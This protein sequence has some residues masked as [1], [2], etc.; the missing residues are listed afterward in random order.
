M[1]QTNEIPKNM[2]S[3][4][5]VLGSS[6]IDLVANVS[7]LPC[8]GETV[9]GARLMQANGGKGANQ[10]VAAARLGG[11]VTFVT[12]LGDDANGEML[13]G[14][15][16]SDG[17][18]TSH[19][20]TVAGEPTGTALIFV[21]EEGENCIAVVPGANGFLTKEVVDSVDG[22]FREAGFMLLQLETPLDA[23]AYAIEKAHAQGVKVILNPAPAAFLPDEVF[24]CLHLIT[25][26]ETEAELL[27]GVKVDSPANA[28]KAA[29]ILL[30]KGVG[31]VVITL[32]SEGAFIKT[33]GT[34]ELVPALKVVAK[35]S[36]AAGDTFSG[37]LTVALSEGMELR[38]AVEFATAAAAISVTRMGAQPS[39][40]YRNEL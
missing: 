16:Q 11:D 15:F 24:K 10:A 33:D 40:P 31:N 1:P 27:T 38:K 39:I 32:G 35:D 29:D 8:P 17:I 18:D 25:P 2:K 12:C 36:T 28:E 13:K 34:C 5:L 20:K 22:L 6:N 37:A 4:I 14:Q 9:G 19:I 23:V 21:S 3:K 26:N 30:G 7:H